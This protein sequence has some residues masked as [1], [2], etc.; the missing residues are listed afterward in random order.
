MHYLCL[1]CSHGLVKF[2]RYEVFWLTLKNFLLVCCK[3]APKKKMYKYLL[4]PVLA[5]AMMQCKDAPKETEGTTANAG[6]P[7]GGAVVSGSTAGQPD[8]NSASRI[9][10]L[11]MQNG[12]KLGF[13]DFA[14]QKLYLLKD[15]TGGTLVENY[16]KAIQPCVYPNE[17]AFAV[18]SGKFNG[19][20]EMRLP[21]FE[22]TKVDS[23]LPKSPALMNSVSVAFEFWCVGAEPFG[24]D[25]EISNPEGGI[26]L[27]NSKNNTASFC[28]WVPP[29][30][31]GNTYIYDVPGSP[32]SPA[33]VIRITKQPTKVA[34]NSYDYTC[35]LVMDKVT[36]KGGATRGPGKL[37]PGDPNAAE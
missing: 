1:K 10:G 5:L 3:F 29:V 2:G 34:G 7:V 17:T 20:G 25:I 19:T 23:L 31:K 37:N 35:E 9:R 21:I 32:N 16:K 18:F 11:M 14:N 28:P 27:Q 33:I 4:L 30:K 13:M 22:V 15:M 24:W 36:Y 12:E 26:F 8:T 6:Q